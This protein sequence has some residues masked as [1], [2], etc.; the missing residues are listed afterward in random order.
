[1]SG[2]GRS[3]GRK[4]CHPGGRP[5]QNRN[6]TSASTAQS[7]CRGDGGV[8]RGNSASGDPSRYAVPVRRTPVS[9]V[10]PSSSGGSSS[11]GAAGASNHVR[12]SVRQNNALLSLG[13]KS[14]S[15]PANSLHIIYRHLQKLFRYMTYF[16]RY[17]VYL[18][19]IYML[20]YD[21]ILR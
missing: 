8:G 20:L 14:G 19:M 5:R 1:M 16:L 3:R 10:Q 12:R 6:T 2:R 4:R 9:A 21:C 13:L 11:A 7:F 18:Y 15:A 17:L